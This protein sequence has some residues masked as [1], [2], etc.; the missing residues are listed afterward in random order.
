[1]IEI[2]LV[3]D[4]YPEVLDIAEL[5]AD[6]YLDD[7]LAERAGDAGTILRFMVSR[8]DRLAVLRALEGAGYDMRKAM[9]VR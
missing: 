6:Y 7:F 2:I 5:L 4:D 3:L 1:M 9:E 8:D